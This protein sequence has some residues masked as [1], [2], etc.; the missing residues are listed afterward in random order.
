MID[1][2]VKAETF[3]VRTPL[4][5]KGRLDTVLAQ[6]EELQ[7]RIKC[8]AE[9]GENVLHAHTKEDHSFII[10]QGKA[11]FYDGDNNSQVLGRNEGI[12]LPRGAKYYFQSCGD[13]PLVLLRVSNK[14]PA[15]GDSRVAPDGHALPGN[16]AENKHEDGVVIPGA[17]YE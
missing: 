2:P 7:I 17:F 15:T 4:T 14:G 8:Y 5:S 3:R 9:G 1:S 13:E 11:R 16:S 10:L 12:L 6:A